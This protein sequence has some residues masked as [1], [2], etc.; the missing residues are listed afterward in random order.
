MNYK[1]IKLQSYNLHMI[2][3]DKFKSTYIEVIFSSEIKKETITLS[4]FLSTI[5]TYSTKTYNTKMNFSKKLE[6]LYA[7]SIFANSYR[8]G[9]TFNI[10][11]NMRV[12]NDKYTENGLFEQSIDFLNDILFNPNVKNN[13]FDKDSFIIAKNT[14]KSQI[15][16]FK[17]DQRAYSALKI[18]ELYDSEEPFSY[19]LK[20][21]MEDLNK[22]NQTNLY[23]FYKEFIKNNNIDVFVL[24]DIDFDYVEKVFIDKLKV[25]SVLEKETMFT[26]DAKK[27]R[28]QRKEVIE[29]DNTNQAKLAIACSLENLTKYEK[30]FV[31]NL[32]NI[33]LGGSSDSKFFKNIREK[34]SLCYYISSCANKLDNI[35]T[36]FSG[37]NK[38]NYSKMMI[39]IEKEMKDMIDGKFTDE[40]IEKAKKYYLSA[41]EEIEDNP[42]QIIASYYAIDKLNVLGIEERKKQIV[43]VTKKDIMLLANKVFIDTVFLLGGDKK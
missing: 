23:D 28:E 37:I 39:L 26:I 3:T 11:F 43:K 16:R 31:L 9:R 13:K 40:D 6:D 30:D 33:I 7:A 4:N 34:F 24:G 35:L 8:L 5:L 20:G 2:K 42:N 22:I 41:L 14:E 15:E 29:S 25:P 38:E 1:K 10:D 36:I 27:H 32:Y 21:Y 18:L 17:E 12:L 19:N